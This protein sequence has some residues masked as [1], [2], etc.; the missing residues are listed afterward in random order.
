MDGSGGYSLGIDLGTTYTAAA[1][2]VAGRAEIIPLGER[3]PSIPSVLYV[4]PD[5][6]VAAGD[7]ANRHALT[8]PTRIA[9]ELKRRL[10]DPTAVVIAG[11][12]LP[13]EVLTGHLL[14]AVHDKVVRSKG[15][16]PG[17]VTLTHPANWGPYKRAVLAKAVDAAG[18]GPVTLVDEPQAAAVWYASQA[19]PPPG[20]T[21]AVY[22]LGGGTFDAVVLRCGDDGRFA[23]V[24]T[25]D[26]VERLGG[27]DFDGIVF[28]E[29]RKAL[30]GELDA[31][32][33]I[34]EPDE[35]TA[36]ALAE[37]RQ[38]CRA[39]KETLSRE[40]QAVIPVQL[41]GI[42]TEVRLTQPDL[43]A[44]IQPALDRTVE[45]LERALSSAGVAPA[46]LDH[47]LVLGGSSRLPLVTARLSEVLDRPV[48][49]DAH[50]KHSVALGA[51]L[52]ASRAPRAEPKPRPVPS[53]SG[54]G[55]ESGP[56]SGA[57]G[58]GSSTGEGTS[59][60]TPA[61][62]DADAETTY[63]TP[64][65]RD[66]LEQRQKV[67]TRWTVV[68]AAAIVVAA[69][70][71]AFALASRSDEPQALGDLAVGDC[72]QGSDPTAL[73]VVSCDE[74]HDG[75]VVGVVD[76]ANVVTAAPSDAAL[77]AAYRG[78]CADPF[79]GYYGGASVSAAAADDVAL[80]VA[81]PSAGEYRD[82]ARQ[83]VCS[84]VA[85]GGAPRTGSVRDLGR[86]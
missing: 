4:R 34:D 73:T 23:A 67:R 50:P 32:D 25:P 76:D 33:D 43:E 62:P 83:G 12:P 31:V 44:A 48:E 53:S 9:R 37:L 10:G 74:A 69:V 5:G 14:R 79:L 29:V 35:G 36:V 6:T 52:V 77:Q 49:V 24:G 13:T 64:H 38:A 70:G 19:S 16:E 40:Y 28:D 30:D 86:R 57:S 21:I 46:D 55:S 8:N 72:Y 59:G 65:V 26:G 47:V 68:A 11:F 22:D 78:A 20:T 61:D 15:G 3:S 85:A 58:A 81:P 82:G 60:S 45:A 41:P 54:S 51:A 42:H 71:V 27:V 2:H 80:A 56:G 63:P 1:T 7:A 66:L 75:E 84:A 17:H 39:A 18:I